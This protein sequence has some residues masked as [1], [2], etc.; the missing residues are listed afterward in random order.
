MYPQLCV[1]ADAAPLVDEPDADDLVGL[2]HR[3]HI[4]FE[5]KTLGHASFPKQAAC[6]GPRFLQ[7]RPVA[8]DLL[9]FLLRRR[10]RVAGEDDAADGFHGG[11]PGEAL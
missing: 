10:Q 1:E 11:D 8:S 7:V 5:S 9:E 4:E 3:A 2:I 6:L